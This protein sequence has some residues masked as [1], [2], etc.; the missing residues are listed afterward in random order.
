MRISLNWLGTFLDIDKSKASFIA[1]ALTNRG[2]EVEA[3][4]FQSKG[5]EKVV[6]GKIITKDKHP[7]ADK[8]SVLSVDVGKETLQ[9]VCGASN[10]KSGD[11]VAVSLVGAELPN[12]LVIKKTK[13]RNVESSGMCCSM[14]ELGLS[15]EASGIIILPE[16]A[17]VGTHAAEVLSLDDVFITVAT[18]PNRGDVLGYIGIAREVASILEQKINYSVTNVKSTAKGAGGLEVEI[19]DDHCYRYIGRLIK[20][21]KIKPSPDWM[22]RRLEAAGLRSINNIVDITNYVML[23]TGHPLHAFDLRQ[24]SGAKIIVRHAKD[25]EKIK[26]L[27]ETEKKLRTSDMMITDPKKVLAIA[28]VMGG[29]ESGISDDT[30]D[31][32][33]ECACFDPSSIRL[34]SKFH[35]ILTD[36]SYRFERGVDI[37][38]MGQ[39]MEKTTALYKELA[40]P[41]EIYE[42]VDVITRKRSERVV[43]LTAKAATDFI[44]VNIT[45]LEIEKLLTPIGFHVSKTGSTLKI[46]VPSFRNDV[47][48]KADI[49]EEIA[50]LNG[51]DKIPA[52]LPAVVISAEFSDGTNDERL[53]NNIRNILKGFGYLETITYSFVPDNYHTLL[54][55]SDDDVIKLK[56][57]ITETM[58]IMRTSLVTSMLE[59]VKY[60]FN[61]RNMDLRFFEIGKTYLSRK[62]SGH[63][64][65]P[66]ETIANEQEYICGICTGNVINAADWT[67]GTKP[68]NCN[69]YTVKGEVATLLAGLRIPSFDFVDINPGKAKYLHPGASCAVKCCGKECGYIGKVHPDLA[70]KFDL[71]GSDLYI[72][73]LAFDHLKLVANAGLS[74]KE[75]PKFPLIRRDLSFMVPIEVR[76]DK[77]RSNIKKAGAQSL[78]NYGVFDLYNGK[79]I[80]E[81]QKSMAYYFVFGSDERTLSDSE[82]DNSML[83]I[84]DGLKKE[85]LINIRT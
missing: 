31:I 81:G 11:K 46:T 34:T 58:K 79:G 42:P 7:N 57:P 82:V 54:G 16:N 48:M 38:F 15:K 59:S 76:D 12:G 43:E 84:I 49:Y 65:S 78:K 66:T 19:K 30:T 50:R 64:P 56:N 10:M 45:D 22:I 44:G 52:E 68:E 83:K 2:I 62:N 5:L 75:L 71:G 73:E 29:I 37:D 25:N 13:I 55:Y 47:T 1:D 14:S 61:H 69:F 51:Y 74:G 8:L 53:K 18:P 21:V 60:N 20:G 77:I 35:N 80:P 70:H 9:I 17:K 39:V 40:D 33:I 72:F 27:D 28:G 63:I 26:L 4:E 85:F 32:I 41:K 3:I 67:R 6:V 23:E 36:S 24:I